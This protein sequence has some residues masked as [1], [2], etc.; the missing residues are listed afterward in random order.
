MPEHADDEEPDWEEWDPSETSFATHCIAGS[1]AG[2]MEHILMFPVDTLKT[3][4]Q[5]SKVDPFM[6]NAARSIIKKEGI[7]RLYRGVSTMFWGCIPAHATYFSV[8]ELS[9]KKL[10][11]D[12]AEQHRP[13]AAAAS[14]MLATVGHDM[15]MTPMDVM[16]QRLQLGY[17]K[18]M[19]DCFRRVLS[20]EGPRAFFVSLP[21]TL[22]MN[23]PYGA[24]LVSS[25]ESLKRVLNPSGG[26]NM[27]AFLLSGSIAGALAAAVTNPLDVIKTRLQ[28]QGLRP[29]E[30]SGKN[31]TS[32]TP[33]TRGG[34][35]GGG[36]AS[37]SWSR[38][39]GGTGSAHL[40]FARHKSGELIRDKKR[41]RA[42]IL[43]QLH[44]QKS[45]SNMGRQGSGSM[46]PSSSAGLWS[47][48]R[49]IIAEDG[50]RGFMRGIK[51]RV[52]THA[53]AMGISWGTYETVKRVLNGDD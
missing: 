40:V 32:K 50:Y 35:G 26:S 4:L 48:V 27:P 42:K 18:G 12:D 43:R 10:G 44:Q 29:I 45:F 25:H 15:I 7:A 21:T 13:L 16:K 41:R 38:K 24:V 23:L 34:G 51:P 20:T 28:T 31:N 3:H 14:G 52:M 17:Y 8:Y 47:T 5:T 37:P 2:L 33:R 22:A 53:P 1:A 19:R 6:R 30:H 9:K 39:G 46:G 36:V 11:A 49:Q